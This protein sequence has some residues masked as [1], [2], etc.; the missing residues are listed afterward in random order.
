MARS[1][2]TVAEQPDGRLRHAPSDSQ[3]EIRH[4][5]SC[6]ILQLMAAELQ[7]QQ[8][9]KEGIRILDLRGRLTIGD[10]EGAL[11]AAI[12]ALTNAGIVKIV[13]NFLDVAEMD[14]DGLGALVFCDAHLLNRGG[15]LTLLNLSPSHMNLMVL[16]KLDTVFKIY[17]SEQ[18]AV[19]SFFPDR[20]P[21]R[22][23]ILEFVRK[24]EKDE[25]KPI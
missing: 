18:D 5:S 16:A 11:R 20:Q 6:A 19:D 13:L 14:D 22:Y 25:G 1:L 9:D 2:H 3:I 23:D 17:T 12:A 4:N 7:I 15:S 10:S 21:K 8:R 24:Q